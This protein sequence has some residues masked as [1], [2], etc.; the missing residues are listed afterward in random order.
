MKKTLLTLIAALTAGTLAAEPLWSG[1]PETVK[2]REGAK[3]ADVATKAEN[4]VLTIGGVSEG[5]DKKM[6]YICAEI[7]VTPFVIGD[8]ALALDLRSETPATTEGL[9]VRG[10]TADNKVVLSFTKWGILSEKV[11]NLILIPGKTGLLKWESDRI[12]APLDA[13]ITKLWVYICVRGGGKKMNLSVS[14]IRLID[15]PA[16]VPEL[17]GAEL[18]GFGVGEARDNHGVI[19]AAA[20]AHK[21]GAIYFSW[22]VPFSGE[23]AGNTLAFSASTLTPETTQAFY[24]RGYNAKEE[25]ILSYG[26]WNKLLT[27]E[28]K[29]FKLKLG[30]DASGMKWEPAEVKVTADQQLAKLRF[31]IGTRDNDGRSFD[32]KIENLRWAD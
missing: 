6:T 23:A 15:R 5:D 16:D 22:F 10:M 13:E 29:E 7:A 30:G 8:R 9:F 12:Q 17:V 19:T 4:G 3:L 11:R 18:K 26:S 27:G 1:A 21:D 20:T 28:P 24:V 2:L 25:C 14:G 32:A 31:Y